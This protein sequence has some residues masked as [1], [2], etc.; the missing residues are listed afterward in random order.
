MDKYPDYI[1]RLSDNEKYKKINKEGDYIHLPSDR[2]IFNSQFP[3]HKFNHED[4]MYEWKSDSHHIMIPYK[5]YD[6]WLKNNRFIN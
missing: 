4:F 5:D 3:F 6:Y 1:I 2:F